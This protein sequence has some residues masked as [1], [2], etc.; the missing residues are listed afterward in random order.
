MY[1]YKNK[2]SGGRLEYFK[3][4]NKGSI[5][6][7]L[8]PI[9]MYNYEKNKSSGRWNIYF[10][11]PIKEVEDGIFTLWSPISMYN[12]GKNKNSGRRNL[13]FRWYYT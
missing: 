11:E 8:S 7:L 5:I 9:S 10:M 4:L 12:H 6:K 13:Y 1:N 3:V 2:K